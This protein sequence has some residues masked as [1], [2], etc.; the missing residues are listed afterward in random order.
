M[1]EDTTRR[2]FLGGAGAAVVLGA[3][4]TVGA[5]SGDDCPDAAELATTIDE[6]EQRLAHLREEQQRLESE[7]VPRLES[8]T[9]TARE[10]WRE[11]QHQYDDATLAQ[12]KETGLAM[13]ES[14]VQLRVEYANSA[15]F[16]LSTAWYAGDDL[17]LTN[18]HNVDGARPQDTIVA[19]A[20]DGTEFACEVVDRVETNNPD[21]ALLRAA[22]TGPA[23][24]V[25]SADNLSVGDPLVQVGHPGD[26]GNWAI[27][28][29]EVL[30]F[31]DVTY[32]QSE[33]EFQSTVPGMQGS[34][35]SPV[36]TLDGTVVG[37]LYAGRSPME[38]PAS[39]P[40]E[41]APLD[42]RT[43]PLPQTTTGGVHVT[44]DEAERLVE[45]WT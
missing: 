17:L 5:Q 41:P 38:P 21:V 15:S 23:L 4:G 16:D 27:T 9:A 11:Q 14:I 3:V 6:K 44:A 20:L 33:T 22:Q 18:S 36:A 19:S 32:R 10:Q 31:K 8:A 12:A 40:P 7:V 2:A 13:R 43:Q 39:G 28:L 30:N 1:A 45:A 35:G 34:S 25:G 26:L 24:S 29:G 42:V 37:M